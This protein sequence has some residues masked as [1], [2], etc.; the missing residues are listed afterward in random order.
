MNQWNS[1]Q[2]TEKFLWGSGILLILGQIFLI[3][4]LNL[5]QMPYFT[6]FDASAYYVL[7]HEMVTQQQ[8]MVDHFVFNTTTMLWDSPLILAAILHFFLDDIFLCYGIANIIS[9]FFLMFTVYLLCDAL[10]IGFRGKIMVFS[11]LLTPFV[12][13]YYGLNDL[14]YY[15]MLFISMGAYAWRLPCILWVQLMFIEWD[16]N[17]V[18]RQNIW[19]FALGFSFLSLNLLSSGSFLLVFAIAPLVLFVLMRGLV[20]DKWWNVHHNSI[21]IL[22]I[23]FILTVLCHFV[24]TRIFGFY[25]LDTGSFWVSLPLFFENLQSIYLGFMEL[26]GGMPL[27]GNM[28][29][30]TVEGILYGIRLFLTLLLLLGG[31][32]IGIKTLKERKN[33]GR[34][35]LLN[36]IFSHLLIFSFLYT[37]YGATIFEIRYL[38]FLTVALMFFL[39]IF[40]EEVAKWKNKSFSTFMAL[41]VGV[42][43]ISVNVSSHIMLQEEKTDYDFLKVLADYLGEGEEKVVFF[44]GKSDYFQAV[45]ANMR[46]VDFTKTYKYSPDLKE[47]YHC[48]DYNYFDENASYEGGTILITVPWMFSQLDSV[49]QEAYELD[50][51]FPEEEIYI[52]RSSENV[53]DLALG[54]HEHGLNRDFPYT[55]GVEINQERGEINELGHYVNDGKEA[56]LLSSSF[57]VEDDYTFDISI[58]H[59]NLEK[60]FGR[61]KPIGSLDLHIIG[62]G[63]EERIY[64]IPLEENANL[65][66][67]EA[68]TV[69]KGQ[70]IFYSIFVEE[71]T[72]ISIESIE[73]TTYRN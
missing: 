53:V 31:S 40:V 26:L 20:E 18:N 42:S 55:N 51:S 63:L 13:N 4:Y 69:S 48:G 62:A 56:F 36:L 30:F 37:K 45:A 7:A 50:Y 47:I 21:L 39:G 12:S 19:K 64:S 33:T 5:V 6:G 59:Q 38:I 43:L 68:L 72:K 17:G 1:L 46:A 29:V 14:G 61:N 9:S 10:G 67:L 44:A 2:K 25:S 34:L 41:A 52:Y 35:V 70:E 71:G 65:S 27:Q 49:F 24:T 23:F 57:L 73:F 58:K 3:C 11:L 66:Q 22:P 54:F 32:F 28:E 15:S 60:D 16:K 8:L